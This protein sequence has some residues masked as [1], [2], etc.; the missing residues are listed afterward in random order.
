MGRTW[1]C[2]LWRPRSWRRA[3]RVVWK[4]TSERTVQYSSPGYTSTQCLSLFLLPDSEKQ[5]QATLRLDINLIVC[6]RF[7]KS[8]QK[9]RRPCQPGQRS[10]VQYSSAHLPQG[11]W[12]RRGY[13]LDGRCNSWSARLSSWRENSLW[14]RRCGVHNRKREILVVGNDRLLCWLDPPGDVE[15]REA[16]AVLDEDGEVFHIQHRFA[17]KDNRRR[18]FRGTGWGFQD[19]C[20]CAWASYISWSSCAAGHH[21][22]ISQ[23]PLLLLT[24]SLGRQTPV[25]APGR[26]TT[27]SSAKLVC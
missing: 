20:V 24:C 12:G 14:H 26:R 18:R 23:E 3:S 17:G 2:S 10:S 16:N 5:Q 11:I 22:L 6:C 27:R 25:I 19:V 7:K 15:E 8:D 9:A 13:S 21:P 1:S 4:N